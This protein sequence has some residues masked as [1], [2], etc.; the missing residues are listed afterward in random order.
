MLSSL[1][2]E[3][4]ILNQEPWLN[5][6][7]DAL[8]PGLTSGANG[9]NGLAEPV[10]A[11]YTRVHDGP[12]LL[13]SH[14][15]ANQLTFGP[16]TLACRLASTLL[17]RRSSLRNSTSSIR[18]I[19]V[20]SVPRPVIRALPSHTHPVEWESCA[21]AIRPNA[22]CDLRERTSLYL[23]I[24]PPGVGSKL[25]VTKLLEV[26]NCCLSSAPKYV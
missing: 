10:L 14:S 6:L 11:G 19:V 8:D 23:A 12:Y 9:L 2:I 18:A 7:V 22:D 4:R 3:L 5:S 17:S 1:A 26:L 21:L 13:E 25:H 24:L 16:A 20:S 15:L